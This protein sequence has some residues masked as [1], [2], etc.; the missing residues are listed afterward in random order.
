SG[1]VGG[2][3]FSSLQLAGIG[4]D[5]WVGLGN[6]ATLETADFI[7]HFSSLPEIHTVICY[8]EGVQNGRSFMAAADKARQAGK[9]VVVVKS[10]DHPESLRSTRSHTGKN[11]SDGDTY[12]GALRQCGVI[13]AASLAELAYVMTLLIAVGDRLGDK[14]GIISASGGATSL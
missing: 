11:P 9:R 6:E 3:I 13:Q 14:L 7:A 2:L 4:V 5:Y 12:A 10:G 1:S 8:M